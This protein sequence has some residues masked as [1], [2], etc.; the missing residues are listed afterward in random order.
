MVAID[1]QFT[2]HLLHFIM[3]RL[4]GGLFLYCHAYRSHASSESS[5]TVKELTAQLTVRAKH[6]P[7]QHILDALH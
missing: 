2:W 7:D 4:E 5:V 1:L 6:I 3:T